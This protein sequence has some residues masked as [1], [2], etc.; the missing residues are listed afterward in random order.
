MSIDDKLAGIQASMSEVEQLQLGLGKTKSLQDRKLNYLAFSLFVIKQTAVA[1]NSTFLVEA[2]TEFQSELLRNGRIS[3]DEMERG[4]INCIA[5]ANGIARGEFGN[6]DY[7]PFEGKGGVDSY[8]FN[9]DQ[10][11]VDAKTLAAEA[12]APSALPPQQR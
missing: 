8:A 3:D 2:Y 11:I 1:V 5:R 12:A 6:W 10:F 4:H 9:D 7:K